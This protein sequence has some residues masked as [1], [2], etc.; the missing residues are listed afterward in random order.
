MQS[1]AD[2]GGGRDDDGRHAGGVC[3]PRVSRQRPA[4]DRQSGEDRRAHHGGGDRG[5]TP[6]ERD[7]DGGQDGRAG[8]RG[9]PRGRRRRRPR[10]TATPAAT[11]MSSTST[12]A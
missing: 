7:H 9:G 10:C 1:M 4:Q 12:A 3:D 5:A 2:D 8:G 6:G 11:S